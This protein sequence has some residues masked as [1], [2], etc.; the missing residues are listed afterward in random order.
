MP[1]KFTVKNEDGTEEEREFFTQAEIDAKV[2]E[3]KGEY[4]KKINET[5]EEYDTRIKDLE[6]DS[7]PNW[8][9]AREKMKVQE[10]KI[11]A[12]EASGK[13]INDAGEVVDLQPK[14]LTMEEVDARARE[15][16]RS[17]QINYRKEEMFS[18]YDEEERKVIEHNFNKLTA[19]EDLNLSNMQTFVSQAEMLANPNRENPVRRAMSATP[20]TAGAGAGAESFSDS[21]AGKGLA[22]QMGLKYFNKK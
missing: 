5:K 4:D 12:L 1:E 8:K 17:E 19:G 2:D 11:Q 16:A 7:N 3:T 22:D 15:I 13:T 20:G 10:A 21:E 9:E 14:S 18:N 6:E